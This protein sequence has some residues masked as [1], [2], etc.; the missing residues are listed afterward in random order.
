M[1][2]VY[3]YRHDNSADSHLNFSHHRY[4][5]CDELALHRQKRLETDAG[6][7]ISFDDDDDAPIPRLNYTHIRTPHASPCLHMY[8]GVANPQ[9]SIGSFPIPVAERK[10]SRIRMSPK[11]SRYVGG[12]GS[13]VSKF[14][15]AAFPISGRVLKR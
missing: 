5:D 4:N 11:S 7:F 1:K 13:S 9:E 14:C 3:H 6:S 15:Q 10:A 2:D 12:L 8:A